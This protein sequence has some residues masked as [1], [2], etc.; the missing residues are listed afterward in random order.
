MAKVAYVRV[1]TTEQHED[2]QISALEPYKID[3][4]FREKISGKNTERP[5]FRRMMEYVR[6]GDTVYVEDFSRLSRSLFD[7]LHVVDALKAKGVGM[8]S[9]KE[10]IDTN[11][12]AGRMMLGMVGVLNQFELDNLHE[13]QAEGIAKAKAKGIYKGRKRIERPQNWAEVYARWKRREIT[14]TEYQ[15][16][17]AREVKE[18]EY[19]GRDFIGDP[20]I[21]WLP[22]D[23][24]LNKKVVGYMAGLRLMNGFQKTIFW[25]VAEVEKHADKYSQ[26]YRAYKKYGASKST[27]RSGNRESP[28]ASDFDQ[29]AMKTV[30]K[31]LISKYGIMSTE[32]QNAVKYD[33]AAINIDTETGEET[34]DYVDNEPEPTAKPLS[35]EQQAELLKKYGADKVQQALKLGGYA[36]LNEVTDE[37]VGELTKVLDGLK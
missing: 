5:E 13:R 26:G 6:E 3:K 2:R 16:L 27:A 9:L 36:T 20:L 18:G 29:M 10:N 22:D 33:Q 4:W 31:S 11:T 12:A 21:E 23:E 30:L 19:K 17:G 32:I 25:T 15:S 34:V 7:L 24:R 8:V 28:W 14:G 35:G 1:S 37:T